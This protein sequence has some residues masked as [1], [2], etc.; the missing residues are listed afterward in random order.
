MHLH[1]IL[2][3]GKFSNFVGTLDP[4]KLIKMNMNIF[5]LI[6]DVY[7]LLQHFVLSVHIYISHI[8]IYI[9]VHICIYTHTY[10]P[11]N[12]YPL[13]VSPLYAYVCTFLHWYNYVQCY[14]TLTDLK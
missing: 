8:L 11:S 4:Q 7:I 10:T 12:T 13:T 14:A 3:I 2:Q 1:N 5:F 9:Y 6:Y